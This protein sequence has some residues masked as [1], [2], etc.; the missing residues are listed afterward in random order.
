MWWDMSEGEI[1]RFKKF[2]IKLSKH[3]LSSDTCSFPPNST[4]RNSSKQ[5]GHLPYVRGSNGQRLVRGTDWKFRM[6][7]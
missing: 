4:A 3:L 1:T 7:A 5:D 6:E 2:V